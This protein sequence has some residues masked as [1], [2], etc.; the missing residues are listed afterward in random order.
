MDLWLATGNGH[1]MTEFKMLMNRVNVNFHSQSE[2]PAFTAP[3]ETGKTFTDNAR[4]K[5]KALHSVKSDQWVMAE[6]SGLVCNGLNGSPGIYSARYAGDKA[7]D[8]ENNLKVLQMMKIRSSENR[9]AHFV[10]VVI[11]RSPTGEEFVFEGELKGRISDAMRGT[12]GFGY[13]SIF[14]PEGEEKKTLAELGQAHKN[15]VSHRAKAIQAMVEKLAPMW[16]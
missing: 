2:I 5:V 11:V 4:I 9:A 16:A 12:E 14:I 13:D 7:T 10:S 8:V 15:K 6:D 3:P 1:K